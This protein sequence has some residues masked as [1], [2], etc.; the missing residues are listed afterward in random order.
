M[1]SLCASNDP[2]LVAASAT[3]KVGAAASP[4]VIGVKN[5]GVTGLDS[6]VNAVIMS[7]AWSCGNGFCYAVLLDVHIV[8][9]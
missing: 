7:A 5:V 6:L 8:H 1:N 2:A 4:W 9:L 3:G